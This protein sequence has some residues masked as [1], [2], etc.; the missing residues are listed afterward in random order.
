MIGGDRAIGDGPLG[1]GNLISGNANFGVGLWDETTSLNTIQGNYIGT[2]IDSTATWDHARDGIHS[3][4]AT[5]NLITGNVIGGNG[6]AGVYLCCVLEGRNTVTGNLIGVGPRGDP[7]GNQLAGV[8]IDRTSH[9]V[10]GPGNTIAYNRGD[11]IAFWEDTP[12]NT[13]TQNSIRDNGGRGI[14]VAS[15]SPN[16]LQPPLIINWDLQAGTLAGV[17]CANCS[18]EIFS[19]IGDEGGIYEGRSQAGEDGTFNFAK[20]TSFTGPI[21]TAIATTSDGTTTEFSLPTQGTGQNLS[22]QVCNVLSMM[23]LQTK[24]SNEL[25]DNRTGASFNELGPQAWTEQLVISALDIG[26]KRLD[27]QFGDVEAPIDWSLDEYELPKQFDGFVDSLAEIGIALNYMLHFWDTTGHD[28]GEELG[29]PRFQN[30]VEVQE[31]LDYVRFFVRHFKGRIPYYTIWSEPDACRPDSVKC[32]L[33]ED[34]IALAKQVI[35]V[36][37]EEDPEA[38]IVSAPNVLFFAREDLFT[39][40]KSD[41]VEQFDVISW[42]PIYD[43]TPNHPFYGNFYYEYPL[44]IEQIQQTAAAQG[45]KGEFWGTELSWSSEAYCNWE[46]CEDY[47]ASDPRAQGMP[48]TDL[49]VAKYYARGIVM[50]LGMDVGVGLGALQPDTPWSYPTVR[51]LNTVMAGN[52]PIELAVEVESQATNLMSFGFSLPDGDR[53]FALW[54]DGVAVDEDPGVP[55]TL[56]FTNLSAQ[57]VIAID[58]LH[59]FEQELITES[60]D[61]NLVIRDLLVRDYPIILRLIY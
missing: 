51:N 21:L 1:Q 2:N 3:N 25:A 32:I 61:G 44:I 60:E 36:I 13:I 28:A 29:N 22:L 58:V 43:V 20:G 33:P 53:L 38:K 5:Q 17:A 52:R 8:L 9:N 30:E 55:G 42:H 48:E 59:G 10:V 54:T 56:T 16:A 18:V 23:Q 37:R 40:L 31:F 7:I 34:Y 35:P 12:N 41:I 50:Q 27:V 19:D 11:G 46:P 24:P 49:Q 45:F 14:G 57:K 4:G 15:A 39:L 47:I 26:L 6:S